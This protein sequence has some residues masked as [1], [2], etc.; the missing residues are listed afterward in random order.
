MDRTAKSRQLRWQ[1]DWRTTVFTAV[2]V[3]LLT[4]LGLWQ[5]ERAAEKAGI[6]ATW[7]SRQ[8][9]VAVALAELP[10]EVAALAYRRV[11][12][13]GS[14][15]PDRDFLLD[16]RIHQGRYGV[17]VISPLRQQAD[18]ALVLVNRGWIAADPSRRELPVYPIPEGDLELTASVY[19]PLGRAYTL[20]EPVA[21]A[22]WPRRIL[23]ADAAAL[24]EMLGESA[25]GHILRLEPASPGALTIDWPVVNTRPEKHR[26]YA[27][28]WFA[29]AVV[30]ALLYLWRSTNIADLLRGQDE[31]EMHD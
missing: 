9:E 30:L 27:T 13:V 10:T 22:G 15:L 18:G 14:F 11:G 12:L 23:V 20:G 3:P 1:G 25:Y 2:L 17:E 26:A 29:M 8:S 4:G 5:L 6:A 24:A 16:N 7:A 21:E 19:I 28:Q 31:G